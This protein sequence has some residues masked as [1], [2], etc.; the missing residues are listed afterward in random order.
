M[1]ADQTPQ[2]LR[3]IVYLPD[4]GA[5]PWAKR[6]ALRVRNTLPSAFPDFEIQFQSAINTSQAF[7]VAPVAH[8]KATLSGEMVVGSQPTDAQL[9]Q[10]QSAVR[11]MVGRAPR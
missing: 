8:T 2:P 4:D 3:F 5:S 6:T 7:T 11:A 10:V 1:A 9:A